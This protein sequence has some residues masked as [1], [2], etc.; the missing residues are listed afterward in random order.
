MS[1]PARELPLTVIGF[2]LRLGT[3]GA[4]SPISRETKAASGLLQIS[5]SP[6]SPPATVF[7]TQDPSVGG[8]SGAPIIDTGK[9]YPTESG[10]IQFRQGVFKVY[11]MSIGTISDDTGGK[12]GVVVPSHFIL[13]AMRMN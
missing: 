9:S 6:G 3:K 13:E 11:G 10:G 8:F 5:M 2:P 4:F 12:L 7:V 1:A